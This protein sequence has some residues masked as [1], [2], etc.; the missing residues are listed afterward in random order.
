MGSLLCFIIQNLNAYLSHFKPDPVF[1]QN[2]FA[3]ITAIVLFRS[4]Y[5]MEVN[6][7]PSFR[8]KYA[9]IPQKHVAPGS[10]TETQIMTNAKRDEKIIRVMWIMV[11]WGLS[12]FLGGFAIWGLDRVY[13]STIRRWRREVGLPWGILL[14]G[15]GWWS[16]ISISFGSVLADE[17]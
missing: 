4:M 8:A 6:I 12:I 11:A 14:E 13:C 10:I 9:T 2:A 5:I 16:A 1:H 15:H 17:F 3:L 7:R